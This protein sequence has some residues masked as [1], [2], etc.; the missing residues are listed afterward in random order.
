MKSR[1]YD[2]ASS[3]M[4]HEPNAIMKTLSIGYK[5]LAKNALTLSFFFWKF[6]A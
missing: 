1:N 2:S 5:D 4:G 6:L 3:S